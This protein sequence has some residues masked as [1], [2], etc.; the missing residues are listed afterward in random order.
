MAAAL[1]KLNDGTIKL[2][3]TIPLDQIQKTREEVMA[4]V[5]KSAN[6][7]GF[8]KGMAPAD[9]VEKS[10]DEA[11][12]REEILKKLLP[13]SYIAAVEEHKLRPILNP[14][15]HV[16]TIEEGKD[17]TYVAE[18]CEMPEI[19]L[20]D[21]KKKVQ[22]INAK[23]K[24]IVPGQE[25]KQANFE[26]IVNVLLET[27]TL[28]LPSII[29]E[30]ETD[31]LLSQTLNEIKSLGLSLDQ[32][33]GSTGKSIESLREEYKLRAKNDITV[34]FTLQ[35]IAEEEKLTVGE[36]EVK[37]ALAQ[38]KDDRERE[39]LQANQYLLASILRQQKTLD[40]LKSL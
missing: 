35:K 7:P 21:Y 11:K 25:K 9:L 34:E 20:G 26:D 24:I 33:L 17:W 31:R 5:K 36:Q 19:K 30:Q 15:I 32:Y 38:A 37:E 10:A 3:I 29:V 23:S 6:I 27:V 12:V 2:T 39:S 22:D 40:F 28:N 16:E 18:T 4:E 13:T 1:T 14:K 8:R